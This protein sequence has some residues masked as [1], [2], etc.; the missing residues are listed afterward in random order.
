MKEHI[1]KF[2]KRTKQWWKAKNKK[3]QNAF[4]SLMIIA[5]LIIAPFIVV[6][7]FIQNSHNYITKSNCNELVYNQMKFDLIYS[8]SPL[9]L[10]VLVSYDKYI[11]LII[12]GIILSWILHGVGFRIA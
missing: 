10:R 12:G 9:W 3:Q 6:T 2:G 4:I 8:D 11:G 1:K 5:S 7:L